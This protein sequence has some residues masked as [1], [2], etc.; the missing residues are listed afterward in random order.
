MAALPPYG[1]SD[2]KAVLG[3]SSSSWCYKYAAMPGRLAYMIWKNV[4]WAI[5][6]DL[7]A[8]D[9]LKAWLSLPSGS[10]SAPT[11]VAASD[12][13]YSTKVTVTWLAVGTATSYS[14]YRS[15]SSDVSTATLLGTSVTTTYDDST[16]TI[17]QTYFYWVKAAN[18]TATSDFSAP[19]SGYAQSGGGNSQSFSGDDTFVVPSGISSLT[20]TM[21]APGGG[22]GA[23]GAPPWSGGGGLFGGGGGGGGEYVTATVPVTAGESLTVQVSPGGI[24]GGNPGG[25]GGSCALLRGSTSLLYALGGSGG[26]GGASLGAGGAGGTGGGSDGSVTEID[27]NPGVAGSARSGGTAGAGGATDPVSSGVGTG[28]AGGNGSPS[29]STASAGLVGKV[30]ITW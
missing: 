13:T 24:A 25:S 3:T 29:P 6:D 27:R 1:P 30:T 14:I 5:N 8:S 16:T 4:V 23:S 10:I 15:T 21:W 19:D 2:F 20:V 18:A 17:G 12:G 26:A 22:G 11:G 9:D 7:S 28:G